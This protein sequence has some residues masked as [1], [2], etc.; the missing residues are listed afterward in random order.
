MPRFSLAHL[1][2]LGCTPAEAAFIAAETGYDFVSFRTIALGLAGEPAY[3]LHEDR[4]MLRQ[5]R[6]ALASTGLGLLDIEVARISPDREVDDYRP[7]LETAAELGARHVLAAGYGKEADR[8]ADQFTRLCE[9]ARP[10]GLT[11]DL[12]FMPFSD[13]RNLEAA[14]ALV[15][16]SGATNAGILIDTLHFDR[17]S[18][19]LAQLEGMAPDLFHYAQL[20]DAPHLEAP[21]VEQMLYTARQERLYLGEG[22]IAVRDIVARLPQVPLSLEIAHAKRQQGLGYKEFARQCLVHAKRYF[23]AEG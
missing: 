19:S 18:S 23:G 16:A 3:P 10:L 22:E 20:N 13:V 9:L 8:V 11:V 4:A 21:S 15:K 12:E 1:T 6:A 2:V 17:S 7:A 14:H 5:T